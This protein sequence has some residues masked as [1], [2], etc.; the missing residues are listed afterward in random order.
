LIPLIGPAKETYSSIEPFYPDTQ[1]LDICG[2]SVT[3]SSILCCL[4][5][6]LATSRG[7]SFEP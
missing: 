4:I 7:S 6:S 1:I 5:Q 3:K 2:I